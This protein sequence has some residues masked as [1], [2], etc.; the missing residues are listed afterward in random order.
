MTPRSEQGPTSYTEQDSLR[1]FLSI[2]GKVALGLLFVIVLAALLPGLP[3]RTLLTLAVVDAVFLVFNSLYTFL[4]NNHPDLPVL[5]LLRA[6]QMPIDV[7]ISTVVLYLSGGVLTPLFIGYM[8]G[9]LVSII[10]LDPNGV[11]RTAAIAVLEYCALAFLEGF[12]ILPAVNSQWGAIDFQKSASATTYALYILSVSAL[13]GAGAYMANRVALILKERNNRIESQLSELSLLYEITNSLGS[14]MDEDEILR[15][16]ATTLKNLQDASLCLVVLTGE[17]GRLEIK[18]WAGVPPEALEK[19]RNLRADLPV[20]ASLIQ[21]GEPI[22]IA[23]IQNSPEYKAFNIHSGTRSAYAFPIKCESQVLGAISLSFDRVKPLEREYR[24]LLAVIAGQAGVAL[25]RAQLLRDSQRMALEMSTLYDVGLHTGSTLSAGEVLQRTANSIEKLMSPDTFY[26]ALYDTE[27]ASI[28]FEIFVENGDPL[29]MINTPLSEGGLTARIIKSGKPLLVQDWADDGVVYKEVARK[30][31]ADMLSYLGVP[32]MLQDRVIG[33][34]SVQCARPLAFTVHDERLLAALAAQTAMALE[35][36]RLHERTEYQ[37]KLDSMTQV[38][39]HG[40]FV[41]LVR[42][43]VSDAAANGTTASLI[44]VDIDY[45]KSYNDAYGHVA[46]DTVLK[47]VAQTIR[48]NVKASDAVGRWGGEEFGVL[49]PGAS[50][51]EAQRVALRVRRALRRLSFTDGQGKVLPAPTIS[52]GVSTYPEPSGSA[53]TLIEQADAA[54][55]Q[56]KHHGRNQL[57]LCEPD[58]VMTP[59]IPTSPLQASDIA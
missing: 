23:D 18:A 58:G 53:K 33:V 48:D 50:M 8:L 31:G 10:M 42:H 16:L 54:L 43:A 4:L 40:Y 19:L 57:I 25:Q 21:R 27:S 35:N 37:A 39:N 32:M 6:A 11:Y 55:Y 20:F 51:Y 24:E 17:D 59:V 15:Y 45:F 44:M 56:A 29:P 9:I 47:L 2:R 28:T 1:W 38:Y 3:S 49:L 46:G 12:H 41:D 22:I 52:Q 5:A 7:S 30:I 13:L 14:T 34:I 36:A 26:I